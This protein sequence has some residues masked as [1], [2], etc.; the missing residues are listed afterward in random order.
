MTKAEM[1]EVMDIYI[2][3]LYQI[4]GAI[5]ALIMI[6]IAYYLVLRPFMRKRTK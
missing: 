4:G 3:P 5:C 6:L 2:K 1:I